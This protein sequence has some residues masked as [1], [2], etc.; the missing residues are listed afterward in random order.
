MRLASRPSHAVAAAVLAAAARVDAA[1]PPSEHDD[2]LASPAVIGLGQWQYDPS[3]PRLRDAGTGMAT[4][5]ATAEPR[6]TVKLTG[7]IGSNVEWRASASVPNL[8]VETLVMET[9]LDRMRRLRGFSDVSLGAR[10]RVRGGDAGW[11]PGVAWLADVDS[12]TGSPAFRGRSFRPSLRATAQWTLPQD[13]TLGVMPGLYRDR[14]DDG[15]RYVAGV[16]AV[17]LGKA[18]TPRLQSFVEVAAQRQTREQRDS[19]LLDIDTGLAY[20]TSRT[21][22]YAFVVSRSLAGNATQAARGGLSVSSRF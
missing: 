11:L 3:F 12:T 5:A 18:W 13:M 19:S 8:P 20:S 22:Q 2:F 16:M 10:W 1:S 21:L 15:R 14:G 4:F 6:G 7:G 9:S 17:T